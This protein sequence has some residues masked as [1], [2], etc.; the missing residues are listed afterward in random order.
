MEGV[1]TFRGF[2]TNTGIQ[3]Q[4][5]EAVVERNKN[6]EKLLSEKGGE[7]EIERDKVEKEKQLSEKRRSGSSAK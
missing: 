4:E 1:E 7:A 3:G 6:I 2:P 5:G